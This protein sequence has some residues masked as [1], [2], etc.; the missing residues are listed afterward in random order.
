MDNEDINEVVTI[1]AK[2]IRDTREYSQWARATRSMKSAKPIALKPVHPD[3]PISKRDAP[4][5][6][7]LH[8]SKVNYLLSVG[9]SPK[10]KEKKKIYFGVSLPIFLGVATSF[11]EKNDYTMAIGMLAVLWFFLVLP[12]TVARWVFRDD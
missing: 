5:G 4:I 6:S 11:F 8:N 7:I 12:G 1:S 9:R 3:T 2:D 10:I